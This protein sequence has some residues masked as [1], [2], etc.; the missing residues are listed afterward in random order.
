MFKKR[1]NHLVI[2]LVFCILLAGF[3]F[4]L[5]NIMFVS[6]TVNNNTLTNA[7]SVV[8][9]LWMLN[10][11]QISNFIWNW[12]GTNYSF[13]DSGL[14][15]MMNFN[16][17][18]AIGDNRTKVVD[19]S[20][21]KNNGTIF[22]AVYSSGYY[23]KALTF[24]GNNDYVSL[25]NS[26]F[27]N[28]FT[29]FTISLWLKSNVASYSDNAGILSFGSVPSPFL[30][31]S[32]SAIQLNFKTLG[33]SDDDGLVSTSFS[34]GAWTNLVYVWNGTTLSLYK[35][36]VFVTSD[37]TNGNILE[38][39]G[40][41]AYVGFAG[42]Y[43][44]WNGSIDDLRIWNRSLTR[45]EI[46]QRYI[47][48]LNKYDADKWSFYSN[49]SIPVTNSYTYFACVKNLSG[50]ENCTD[51]RTI[52]NDITFANWVYQNPTP[53]NNL[54]TPNLSIEVNLSINNTYDLGGLSNIKTF[55]WNWNG[56]NYT[57]FD[58]TVN[59]SILLMMNMDNVTSLGEDSA[60]LIDLSKRPTN[61]AISGA[62]YSAGRF[63]KGLSFDG[64]DDNVVL[65]NASLMNNLT[66]FTIGLWL[67]TD[68]T[69][70][71]SSVQGILT[72][73]SSLT[74]SPS[75][76]IYTSPSTNNITLQF[77]T[78][79]GTI[80]DGLLS[81]SISP[82]VWT[83][84]IYTWNGTLLSVYK[85]GVLLT[86]DAT[87]GNMLYGVSS[88]FYLGF[89]S[90][91]T[92]WNGSMDEVRIL[93]RALNSAEAYQM[94]A[95]NFNRLGWNDWQFY[96]NQSGL[97][98]KK[99]YTFYACSEDDATNFNCSSSRRVFITAPLDLNFID[100]NNQTTPSGIINTKLIRVLL[101]ATNSTTMANISVSLYNASMSRINLTYN[102]GLATYNVTFGVLVDGNYYF[103]SVAFDSMGASDATETRNVTID[104]VTPPVF[105]T[106]ANQSVLYGQS[107][108]YQIVATDTSGVSCFTV[109]DTVVFAINCSG[110]LRNVSSLSGT[111][112]PTIS[113]N[114][115]VNNV[116]SQVLMVN[117]TMPDYGAIPLI[118]Y[119]SS[120]ESAGA[121]L[122][123]NNIY[124]RADASG[125][126][127]TIA[128]VTI[129]LYNSA[130]SLINSTTVS[131]NSLSRNYTNL[132]DGRYFFDATAYNTVG[133]YNFTT[134]RNV[135][136][137]T[138]DPVVN[139]TSPT[140]PAGIT[141]SSTIV[142]NL[143]AYD[144]GTGV[145]TLNLIVYN[146]T[147]TYYSTTVNG[148]NVFVTLTNLPEESYTFHGVA[149]DNA[150]RTGVSEARTINITSYPVLNIYS[151]ANASYYVNQS[152]LV[153]FNATDTNLASL[154]YF[155]GTSN[156][157]YTG[158][159]RINYS[160]IGS[161]TW[162]FY[163]NDSVGRL[164][165]KSVTFSI[166]NL[167]NTSQIVD[168]RSLVLNDTSINEL[169]VPYN[170]SLV[171][172]NLSLEIG[173]FGVSLDLSQLLSNNLLTIVNGFNLTRN[174][175]GV[176]YSV[177]IA[178]NTIVTSAGGWDGSFNLP[179]VSTGS[180]TA[181]S[182]SIN[183]V[184]DVGS[185]AELN[186]SRPVKVIIG[187]MAGKSAAWAR[188]SS[189][190]T[191][192]STG[193]N[194][195]S[196]PTNINSI[197]PRE[198][199]IDSGS[200]LVIWTYHFTDFAAYTPSSG[201]GGG[202][203]GG[204][205]S[206]C[207][208]TW[209]CTAWSA[210]NGGIQTRNCSKLRPSCSASSEP[211]KSQTCGAVSPTTPSNPPAQ[212]NPTQPEPSEPASEPSNN[213]LSSTAKTILIVVLVILIA[214]IVW[215]SLSMIKSKKQRTLASSVK[216]RMSDEEIKRDINMLVLQ[217]ISALESGKKEIAMID[218][219]QAK[220]LFSQLKT[221]DEPL[222]N[223]IMELYNK[224]NAR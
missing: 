78:T 107:L 221:K 136:L 55:I 202:S 50:D 203:S 76:W 190:L 196:N 126:S 192:I 118:V 164:T 195:L 166:G 148:S 130:M 32:G 155:N 194:N 140:S 169:I 162:I 31:A 178:P 211:S 124:V 182:G 187:G 168:N 13:Y 39:L 216:V 83:S 101:N 86:T 48:S 51:T 112:A 28:N 100:A 21:S 17:V 70:F 197:S 11:T 180:F 103:D 64:I 69:S 57:F 56:T 128:N 159:I 206:G 177:I 27:M 116:R 66:Q 219:A 205:S 44:S 16:N 198:C 15:L 218:Y 61:G 217:G 36:K 137:D 207:T 3:I 214:A 186:F 95:S 188:G 60:T 90:G 181:P 18:S 200:D 63:G 160:T 94:Y 5:P 81:A 75:P 119:D 149:F 224:L 142:I 30:Y 91:R 105:T 115:T 215:I 175:N 47:S 139:F 134:T 109:D 41:P 144:N 185:N 34:N 85:N 23:D 204:G 108:G 131:S 132:S 133:N 98:T 110:Y 161:R 189:T 72:R 58:H 26:T 208:T 199:Y 179:I 209:N 22:E 9:N 157:S 158:L 172:V 12:N 87:S 170:S 212:P 24:D 151:P 43:K 19:L 67:K 84:F 97:T 220:E 102:T 59:S 147:G 92:Y 210:C 120:T 10:T 80:G 129:R 213:G 106:F 52:F 38:S 150:S 171:E 122:D 176:N 163:A 184:L 73:G 146:S 14:F 143:T 20:P 89:G 40:S 49:Q 46:Q 29:E 123:R 37:T 141:N 152:I 6:P 93:S 153:H 138:I 183:V 201:S 173:S 35:D 104:A 193:C 156:V 222:F 53:A 127:Q 79:T 77:R 154:W 33:A 8:A 125:A 165:S 145:K 117:V 4:A 68:Q 54:Y 174:S 167:V 1:G 96:S 111:Y 7:N 135:T 2:A 191:A 99:N 65:S 82:G 88:D 71:G 45:A 121:L 62:S 114:D 25:A 223:R 74:S 113:V 42:G